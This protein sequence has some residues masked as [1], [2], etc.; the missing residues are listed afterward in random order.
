[1]S[2]HTR[3]K[4]SGASQ[5]GGDSGRTGQV[6]DEDSTSGAQRGASLKGV[7]SNMNSMSQSGGKAS[8]RVID[9]LEKE[10]ESND[11][12]SDTE[13]AGLP[14]T[15]GSEVEEAYESDNSN[16]Q[17][18][19]SEIAVSRHRYRM[20]NAADEQSLP[21]EN[22]QSV[23]RGIVTGRT[24]RSIQEVNE[25]DKPIQKR[26]S[27]HVGVSRTES[28]T[29]VL[30]KGKSM[31]STKVSGERVATEEI[32]VRS[33]HPA[34]RVETMTISRSRPLRT[35]Q[36][37]EF[38]SGH[39]AVDT[40]RSKYRPVSE[41]NKRRGTARRT[42]IDDLD[43]SDDASRPISR[44]S[45]NNNSRGTMHR[46][47]VNNSDSDAEEHRS[48]PKSTFGN[49]PSRS[50]ARC[51]RVRNTDPAVDENSRPSP[52]RIDR[53][54]NV[55]HNRDSASRRQY[56]SESDSDEDEVSDVNRHRSH[57][58]DSR[59]VHTND[60]SR[61]CLKQATRDPSEESYS[62]VNRKHE[63]GRSGDKHRR[64][65]SRNRHHRFSS[66][67]ESGSRHARTR[68]SK[69]HMKPEKYDG[70]SCFETFLVQFNNCAQFNTWNSVEK[71][72]YLRW[73]MTGTAAR[74]LW[75]TEEMTYKQVVDRLRSRF[76]D[77]D[78]E[79]KY[80]AELQCRRRKPNES[81]RE[82]AQDIRRLMM[83][84]YPGDHSVTSERLAK[85]YFLNA[86][87][88]PNFEL[89]VREKEPQTLDAA[90][91]YAQRLEV[92]RNAVKQRRQRISRQVAESTNSRSSSLEE[93]VAKIVQDLQKPQH[94]SE[95]STK[96]SQQQVNRD[97]SN[98]SKKR[99]N[100]KDKRRTR[101]TTVDNGD[102]WKDEILEKIKRLELAQQTAEANS[103]KISAENEALNK[104]VERLRHL[105]QCRSVPTSESRP[106]E[107]RN[108]G[109]QRRTDNRNCYNCGESG[110]FSRNCPHPRANRNAG[111]HFQ[112]DNET[113]YLRDNGKSTAA[114]VDHDTYLRLTI[115]HNVYDCLLDTGSEVCLFP[116]Q[117]V[118]STQIRKTNRTLKAANDTLIPI[119]GEVALPV[120]L[121]SYK[122]QVTGLVSR[123]VS[124]PMLGVDFLVDNK[125]VWNFDQS[126]IF[127][128][129]CWHMLRSR[130]NKKHWCRRV[131]L[132]E[133]VV[134]PARSEV[135]IPTQVQ[136]QRLSDASISDDW[137]TEISCIKD[138]LLVSHTLIPQ[139]TW[140]DVPVRM[141]NVKEQPV[142]IESGTVVADLEQVSVIGQHDT[143]DSE[144]TDAKQI[145]EESESKTEY[146]QKL[147]EGV[148][149]SIPESACLA[150][151]AILFKYRDVFSQDEN[152]LGQTDIVM[153]HIDTGNARPVRQP[154]RRYPP[155]HV[156]V[157]SE[158]VNNMLKQNTIEP[159]SSP[160]ASNVV[161][162]K[163]KDGSF[164]CCI[165]YRRLNSVTKRD[166]Y[167]L[168][169]IDD[170]LDAMASAKWFSTIDLRS[171]YHQVLVA[172][173]DRD[174]TTFI[175]PRGMYRYKAMPFGLS[176]AGSTFQRLMDVVMSGLHMDVCLVYLDDIICFSST[177]EEHL[178]RLVR[179]LGRLRT[180]GLKIK[181]EKC[182]LMQK[183]VSFLGHVVSGDGI[184]T[185]PE[186]I[187]AVMEWPVPNSVKEVRSF[188]GLSGYYRRFVKGY[189]GIAAPLHA[190]TRR[191]QAFV[192]TEEAQNAFEALKEALTS[193]PVLAMP[194]DTGNFIL[195]TDAS[196]H[197][198]GAVLSQ[199]QDG[200]ERV[201][202][203][204]S[205]KLDKRE[206]NY[207]VT[208]KE[209]LS[210]VHSLK[211]FK[212]YL[213]GRQF[214]IRTDHAPLTWLRRTPY[215]V[216]QQARW[217]EIME[218]YDF[219]V[220]HRPGCKHGNADAVS[221][222]PCRVKA[223]CCRQDDDGADS[224]VMF[225][226]SEKYGL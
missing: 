57:R 120:S 107:L 117:V 133:D 5:K 122:T 38:A 83:L 23:M 221:R 214:K 20:P 212:Q 213:M 88:D 167:P 70:N 87:D 37:G 45:E 93:R 77:L 53:R 203:Y 195:D 113:S 191:D 160:W 24:Q 208:R 63:R 28:Q 151:E 4:C 128:G 101:A 132:Q 106:S 217:L 165:D 49:N 226:E 27:Q 12:C 69:G 15:W 17:F 102:S 50:N 142:T 190:L 153:H 137:S 90:L 119:L 72:H 185:D 79:E 111:V 186:K 82:L 176:N 149:D 29:R 46:S 127:I 175:C 178:E 32:P 36:S 55:R 140:T 19:D 98:E 33:H 21:N 39:S 10:D 150:L 62:S 193:P 129:E 152:D 114:P 215:P 134:V 125:V 81:L 201:I 207:C 209:L 166:V 143:Y 225:E 188:L 126:T 92:F 219:Q 47:F 197:T 11:E 164:R 171:A 144:A 95:V 35:M 124:E 76:G 43:R 64:R 44:S 100:M 220:E 155:A 115:G 74:M 14:R 41:K 216:G 112:G 86:F 189:A 169:R 67:E 85:E 206:I 80:Q 110:H 136:F 148:D 196:E 177:V 147:I 108:E 116:E 145:D 25:I 52:R 91:K 22:G 194:N 156:E 59:V 183:S 172:P 181:P 204:A 162:V 179:I 121:G 170:C 174:K 211:Y 13:Y 8:V 157:I 198:I 163:K 16:Y 118:D 30:S 1:M 96:Q 158:Y 154:L 42:H 135:I 3:S 2:A 187:K 205:R 58:V 131:I 84:S 139:D 173:E 192:W 68:K 97:Q 202:A 223:C 54:S 65:N 51:T 218:E 73:S 9:R 182:S 71:L 105:E 94:Q 168:P 75:G 7:S 34:A 159:A 210:I 89:S 66:S 200:V 103:K 123:H 40:N 184:A 222:R 224:E 78:M 18:C 56:S 138:G 6:A 26:N 109:D 61:S 130:P 199:V 161:L 141:M 60:Y 99:S 48:K 31:H 180:A 146:I 104:E